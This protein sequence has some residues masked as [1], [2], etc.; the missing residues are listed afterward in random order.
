MNPALA[1]LNM[2]VAPSQ[3]WERDPIPDFPAEWRATVT[4]TAAHTLIPPERMGALIQSIEHV[5]AR[6]IRGAIVECGVWKGGTGMA[7]ALSLLR[8]AEERDLYL[9]DTYEGMAPPT[10]HD[11]DF[12]GRPLDFDPEN[13]R[14]RAD[15]HGV[16][17]AMKSTGYPMERVHTVKGKVEDTL[18]ENAPEQIAVLH[19]DTD[20]YESTRHELEHLFPRLSRGGIL[21]IDDYGHFAGA[22]KAVDEY[23]AGQGVFLHRIDYSGRLLVRT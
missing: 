10:R 5:V 19:L 8:L 23:F 16:R 15:L 12:F 22:R 14:A 18:P 11:V 6:G 21:I 9:F 4:A 13:P 20:W 3:A 1:K 2:Q 7:A 17:E